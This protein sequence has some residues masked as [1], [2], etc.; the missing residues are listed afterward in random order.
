MTAAGRPD[1]LT[2][3][4]LAAVRSVTDKQVRHWFR[5]PAGAIGALTE[6]LVLLWRHHRTDDLGERRIG[7]LELA[8]GG[9]LQ[10][11]GYSDALAVECSSNAYLSRSGRLSAQ[12]EATLVRAGFSRPGDGGDN[13]NFGLG[14]HDEADCARAAFSVVAVLTA[15]FGVYAG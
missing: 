15:V 1:R 7:T 10:W 6:D 11:I 4:R 13:P 5:E 9:Y 12:D 3:I 14:V 2:G 8:S